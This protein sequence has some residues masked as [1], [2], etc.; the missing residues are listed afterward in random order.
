ME[1][2]TLAERPDLAEAAFAIPYPPGGE[3]MQ[4]NEVAAL[5]RRTRITR[6]WPESTVVLLDD[7][8]C[9]ARGVCVPFAA[10]APEGE[11]RRYPDGGWDQVAV[12]AAED[13]MDGR[14]PDTLCALEV[15]V[16]PDRLR[17]GLSAHV[18]RGMR[19]AAAA[20]GY[21]ELIVPVRPPR[22]ADEPWTPMAEYAARLR[23]DGLPADPWLRVHVRLGA[24][25]VGVAPCSGTVRAPLARWRAWT[26]LPF[27]TDGPVEV[28]GGLSPV[29]VSQAHDIAVY[30]EP[31]VWVR[32]DTR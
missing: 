32:H 22:K 14:E 10:A 18:L 13:A 3:F 23:E 19:S 20:L 30:V 5:V 6:H 27:D 24:T 17:G 7:G 28:P 1:L 21:P 11:R 4:G 16:H 25:V 31:N 2:V 26:G 29:L 15:A 8:E 9:V 12:W